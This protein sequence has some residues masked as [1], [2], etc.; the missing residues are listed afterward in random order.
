M[1]RQMCQLV[2]QWWTGDR[3]RVPPAEGRFLRINPGDLLTLHGTD[4][5]VLARYASKGQ[6]VCLKCRTEAGLAELQVTMS[7]ERGLP[8]LVWT[9]SGNSRLVSVH[10]VQVWPRRSH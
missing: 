1:I 5:E 4:V 8:E 7:S 2:W 3:I 9:E 10:D 6:S